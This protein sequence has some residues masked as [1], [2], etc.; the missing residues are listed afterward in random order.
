MNN[1]LNKTAG[2]TMKKYLHLTSL[3]VA[4]KVIGQPLALPKTKIDFDEIYFNAVIILIN[5]L[6]LMFICVTSIEIY[7]AITAYA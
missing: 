4:P 1:V 5:A 6:L 3:E 7:Y 2:Y